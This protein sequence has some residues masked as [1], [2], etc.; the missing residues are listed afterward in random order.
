MEKFNCPQ[1]Q[2]EMKLVPAGVSKRTGKPYDAF[3][4]CKTYGC[5]GT[6]KIP[7]GTQQDAPQSLTG[8]A[9]MTSQVQNNL[10]RNI[11]QFEAKK[12]ESMKVMA[13]GRDA[14]LL[15]VAEMGQAGVWTDEMIQAKIK[16]WAKWMK[17][18]IYNPPFVS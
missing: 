13:S 10:S 7:S 2:G 9:R 18:N 11:N 17:E 1:C 8:Q 4:G 16:D 12:E 15:T 3:Y 14:V 6:I 5:K